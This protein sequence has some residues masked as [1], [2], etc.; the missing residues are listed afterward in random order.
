MDTIAAISTPIG[1]GGIG[2]I[3]ISGKNALNIAGKVVKYK[4]NSQF[5]SYTMKYG[6]IYDNEELVDEVIVS[7]FKAPKSYT[8]EDVCEINCHGGIL[9]V[10]RILELI[11][12]CGAR[13]AEPGEFTKRAFLNGKMDLSQAEAV[14]D[15]INSKSL[16]ENKNSVQQLEGHLG[17]KIR[18]IKKMLIDIL[19][20][21]EANIDYPEYDVEEVRRE[22]FE[23]VL[24]KSLNELIKLKKTF[25]NGKILKEG[26]NT[27]IVGRPNV[28]K[29]SLLN[30][31]LKEERAIVTEIEGT[32]RDTIEENILIGGIPFKIIDTAGIRETNDF[33]EE[34]G[35]EK[36]KKAI[37]K[38]DLVLI[39]LDST[40]KIQKEEEELIKMVLFTMKK[41]NVIIVINKIDGEK[42][43]TEEDVVEKLSQIAKIDDK[44]KILSKIVKISAKEELGLEE[45]EKKIE[46]IYSME[47]IGNN[48][49]ILITN[50]RHKM[51]IMQTID[52][53]ERVRK[54]NEIGI[55]MDMLSIDLQNAIQNLGE[56]TGESV[57]EEVINEIFKKFCLGK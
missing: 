5:K 54:D 12:K 43:T 39:L 41:E 55:P 9:V 46:E 29:S 21:I 18:E 35:V 6:H 34:I 30:A 40:K 20:D 16:K 14:M 2:I 28:G 48:E 53:I 25:E 24:N 7:Y 31:L 33:V 44:S 47:E 19:V 38:A 56:I 4:N 37:E 36:S 32:T 42:I 49:E 1:Q 51:A 10:R 13:L 57:S 8:G 22:T 45:L 27:V 50:Q 11:L 23:I 52:S 26:I 17:R 15:V 3:R